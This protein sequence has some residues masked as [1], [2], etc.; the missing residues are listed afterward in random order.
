MLP[1]REATESYLARAGRKIDIAFDVD[2]GE[3]VKGHHVVA[4]G[5]EL[6]LA[7]TGAVDALEREPQLHYEFVPGIEEH[8]QDAD[9]FFWYWTLR[10]SDDVATHYRD[11]DSGVRAPSA[12]GAATHGARDL[13]PPIPAT[14]SRL[15]LRFEPPARFEPPGGYRHEL[16]IDLRAGRVLEP[17]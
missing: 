13:G 5:I 11:D 15:V 8:E 2:L 10:V 3:L 14:A 17:S 9:R 7:T 12:G 6:G 16:V 1:G 4:R